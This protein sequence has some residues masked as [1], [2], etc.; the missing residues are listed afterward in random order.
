M[1]PL[2]VLDGFKVEQIDKQLL[3]DEASQHRCRFAA[4]AAAKEGPVAAPQ[5]DIAVGPLRG[6]VVNFR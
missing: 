5:R 6:A 1:Q 4:S 3:P 2:G